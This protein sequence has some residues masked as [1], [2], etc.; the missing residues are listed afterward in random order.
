MVFGAM[1]VSPTSAGGMDTDRRQRPRNMIGWKPEDIHLKQTTLTMG[2]LLDLSKK[3][4]ACFD[5]RF[6]VGYISLWCVNEEA[7]KARGTKIPG[8]YNCPYHEPVP[9]PWSFKK[10]IKGLFKKGGING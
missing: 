5:C 3:E 9:E 8:V 6:C 10:W 7:A 4:R 1:P 2:N